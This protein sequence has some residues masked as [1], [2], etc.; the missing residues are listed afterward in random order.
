VEIKKILVANR[1]EIALRIIRACREM[2]IKSVAIFS[3][4]D[5]LSP[6]VQM[7]D[8]AYH[9]PGKSSQETYLDV[10][11]IIE[12]MNDSGSDAVHPGYGFLSENNE[13]SEKIA[14]QGKLFI[15]P[16]KDA[17]EVMGSKTN[18][19]KQM[20][21]ANVPCVPGTE[22]GISDLEDAKKI[23][24]E[25]GYPILIK[26]AMG[27][28]G[29][30][31]RLVEKE[32]DL[33]SSI[34]A[35]KNEARQAFGDDLVYIEKF[36]EEPRHIEI[37][38]IGD[39]HG[40]YI[41]LNERECSIQR[42]HQKVIEEAPSSILTPE[43]RQKMGEDAIKC[44]KSVN[45]HS[46][47]TVEF[48]VDKHMNYY[49]LEMNTRLQVEHPVTEMITGIDIVKEMIKIASG[50]KLSYT[51][52]DVK[53]YGHAIECRIYA[54]DIYENFMPSTGKITVMKPS[55]G[56]GIREDSGFEQGNV[57]TPYYDPMISK[58][59]AWAKDRDEAI[60]RMKRALKEY[61]ISGIKTTIPFCLLVLDHEAFRK[62]KYDTRFVSLYLDE[63]LDSEFNTEEWA[64]IA[65]VVIEEFEK[66]KHQTIVHRRSSNWKKQSIS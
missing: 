62:G 4:L 29:K 57:V 25:I 33:N 30:G 12:I 53:I 45:Y 22:E 11:K 23:A 47:G 7:A 42:R 32:E 38:I 26:A 35:S 28:G 21:A 17:I 63:L 14:Q 19:R 40:N 66:Q 56:P 31:M 64:A 2:N 36:V 24:K 60:Q 54:E 27:G 58:L 3:D 13:F 59:C 15:G 41:H 48:L 10:D 46:A 50:D 9:L 37:Q 44:A 6:H 52:D 18:A 34:E 8:E 43:L 39:K 61:Q 16:D 20:L 51:Q 65:S 1:G 5:R 55:D 49:F